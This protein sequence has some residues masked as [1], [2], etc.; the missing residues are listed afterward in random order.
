MFLL[1]LSLFLPPEGKIRYIVTHDWTKKMA[2][3]DYLSPQSKEKSAYLWGNDSEW[4][5]YTELYLTPNAS[6]YQDSEEKFNADEV[7]YN[8]KKDVFFVTRD[9][10]SGRM[11]DA[12]EMLGRTWLVEDSLQ[13]PAWKI[14]NDMKEV[15][16]Y[17]CM[18]ARWQDTIKG[19]EIIA[20]FA[21]DLPSSAG[22]DR[23]CGLPG[24]ILEV[25]INNGALVISADKVDLRPVAPEEMALPKKLKGKKINA[26]GFQQLI[27]EHVE[28]RK[29]NE[30]VWF[31][32]IRY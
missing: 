13:C 8:W 5:A 24:L 21:L 18:N 17:V 27:R 16:G 22:P 6:K 20:W 23:F 32:G 11:F 10:Q 26:A 4:K 29:K 31:W 3:V 9:F 2:A 19:Q 30:E 25:N 1:L 14:L 15:S 12:I 7:G 28:S